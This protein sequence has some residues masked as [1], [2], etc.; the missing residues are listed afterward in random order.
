YS[1]VA[2]FHLVKVTDTDK[3][4]GQV[5]CELHGFFCHIPF[6]IYGEQHKF[7]VCGN[8][9][10]NP[11]LLVYD[12]GYDW[13]GFKPH[14]KPLQCRSQNLKTAVQFLITGFEFCRFL[15]VHFFVGRG[16]RLSV[17]C[18]DLAVVFVFAVCYQLV[19][20]FHVEL[21][22]CSG[23][24]DDQ[25]HE[26]QGKV[27]HRLSSL[28]LK[29]MSSA[30]CLSIL[31]K[32]AYGLRE[33]RIPRCFAQY[34]LRCIPKATPRRMVNSVRIRLSSFARSPASIRL[35]FPPFST[36]ALTSADRFVARV[37]N[38]RAPAS[39]NSRST[40]FPLAMS[41]A[42]STSLTMSREIFAMSLTVSSERT[43]PDTSLNPL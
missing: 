32:P 37:L 16:D 27:S 15:P 29:I 4:S 43:T 17:P 34:I 26:G 9:A 14:A 12:I 5:A 1:P 3:K 24:D 18:G 40:G 8:D 28:E 11:F 2:R 23:Q 20:Q 22:I 31:I 41:I 6:R 21:C 7:G 35:S 39:A 19:E 42:F 25:K 38:S 33:L 10:Y 13:C 36:K 30:I